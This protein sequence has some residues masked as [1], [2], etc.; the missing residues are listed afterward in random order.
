M[1]KE[2]N[3]K[4]FLDRQKSTDLSIGCKDFYVDQSLVLGESQGQD[5]KP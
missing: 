5:L 4:S 3:G 2:F 1:I